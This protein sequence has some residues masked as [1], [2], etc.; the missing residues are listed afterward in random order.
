MVW[1]LRRTLAVRLCL[2]MAVTLLAIALSTY[3]GMR[4]ALREQLDRSLYTT[5]ELQSLALARDGRLLA[6]PAS[7]GEEQFA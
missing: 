4:R 3:A 7:V 5:F 6:V 2:T 1:S